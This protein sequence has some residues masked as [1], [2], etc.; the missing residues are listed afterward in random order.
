MKYLNILVNASIWHEDKHLFPSA[1]IKLVIVS[2]F[3]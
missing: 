1:F 2:I 3:I